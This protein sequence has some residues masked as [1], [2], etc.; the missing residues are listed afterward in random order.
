MIQQRKVN[1]ALTNAYSGTARWLR[2]SLVCFC[3]V[4]GSLG[5]W[6]SVNRESDAATVT[7]QFEATVASAFPT[8]GG[9]DLPFAISPG[10]SIVTTMTFQPDSNGP[11][12]P[13][14]GT[15]RFD[16]AGNVLT[17]SEFQIFVAN[18][19]QL[20][21]DHP[22]RIADPNNTPDVDINAVG[23]NIIASCLDGGSDFCGT[24]LE[25]S[26]IGF[27]PVVVFAD[28]DPLLLTSDDLLA[29][30]NVWSA[31]SLREMSLL[32]KNVNTGG[33]NYV[34]AYIRGVQEVPETSTASLAIGL[35]LALAGRGVLVRLPKCQHLIR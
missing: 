27:R 35:V 14:T 24:V 28:L 8:D 13:Q 16:V 34:G 12:Y 21:I 3:I 6:L 17:V 2:S 31:F 20:W 19:Q 30:P 33:T 29:D 5:W 1:M 25:S 22:G 11:V 15:M 23:D 10:D 7:F 18:D 4:L 32:F 26:S 9:A